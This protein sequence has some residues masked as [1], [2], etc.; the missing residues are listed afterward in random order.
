MNYQLPFTLSITAPSYLLTYDG[1]LKDELQ[2]GDQRALDDMQVP[3][4]FQLF[5]GLSA[6]AGQTPQWVEKGV[7]NDGC[8][9]S[10]GTWDHF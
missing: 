1:A 6:D 2:W 8:H 9:Y 10:P 5:L 3:V 7:Q 4:L